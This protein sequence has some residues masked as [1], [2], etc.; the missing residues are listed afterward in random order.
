MKEIP[1]TQGF[2]AIVM[3]RILSWL[4]R[5]SGMRMAHAGERMSTRTPIGSAKGR[6]DFSRFKTSFWAFLLELK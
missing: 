3:T 5:S 1:L 2:K 4:P 6:G